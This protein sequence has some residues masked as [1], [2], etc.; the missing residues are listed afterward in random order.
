MKVWVTRDRDDRQF[1]IAVWSVKPR[2]HHDQWEL[3]Q[4]DD[5][6]E[7]HDPGSFKKKFGF[8]PR[9]GSCKQYELSLKEI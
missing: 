1:T 9:K 3:C 4:T 6:K 2:L 8:T 5:L 7:L